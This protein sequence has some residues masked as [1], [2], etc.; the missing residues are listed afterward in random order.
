MSR[1]STF[2]G[3]F[4]SKRKSTC[5]GLLQV[6]PPSREETTSAWLSPTVLKF[7]KLTYTFPPGA[8]TGY[9]SWFRSHSLGWP[10]SAALQKGLKPLISRGWLHVCPSSENETMMGMRKSVVFGL[11]NS[12]NLLHV[13]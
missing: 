13:T 2:C 7:S 5:E 6:A 12:V 10:K 9:E 8:T 11:R 4:R 1:P 3:K